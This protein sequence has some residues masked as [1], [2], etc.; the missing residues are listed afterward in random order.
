MTYHGTPKT[1]IF[2][3]FLMVN[4]LVFRWPKTFISLLSPKWWCFSWWFTMVRSLKKNH[5]QTFQEKAF[6]PEGLDPLN[7][8]SEKALKNYVTGRRKS[9]SYL[10]YG[11]FSKAFLSNFRMALSFSKK[12]SLSQQLVRWVKGSS[13]CIL[14]WGGIHPTAAS[15]TSSC[16]FFTPT[17]ILIF[18]KE[19]PDKNG[20]K[21]QHECS[22]ENK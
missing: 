17:K 6:S 13:D 10:G 12:W 22:P 20:H 18:F 8:N 2:R 11:S 14:G 16:S 9:L 3:G 21:K 19:N 5:L 4:N 15:P 1:H 7:F